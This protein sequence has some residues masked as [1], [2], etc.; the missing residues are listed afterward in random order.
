MILNIG[1][2]WTT[3]GG[4]LAIAIPLL[5]TIVL[6]FSACVI[7]YGYS[8]LGLWLM[9][10]NQHILGMIVIFLSVIILP[11]LLGAYSY[12]AFPPV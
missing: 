8:Y 10:R 2:L 9:D 11:G 12:L 4:F 7:A 1:I 5:S 6:G 3:V